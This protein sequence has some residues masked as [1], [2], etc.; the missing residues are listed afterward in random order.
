MVVNYIDWI[1]QKK[2]R[3]KSMEIVVSTKLS[4]FQS[5][6][7]M[8]VQGPDSNEL[9]TFTASLMSCQVLPA[10]SAGNRK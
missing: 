6:W 4:R 3:W 5:P 7:Q 8:F 10:V 2:N 1:I 9:H